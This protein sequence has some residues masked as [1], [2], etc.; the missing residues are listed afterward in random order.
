MLSNVLAGLLTGLPVMVAVGPIGL[1]L[2]EQ[3]L[4]RGVRTSAPAAI[5]VAAADLTFA[6]LSALVGTAV[7]HALEA[8][9]WWLRLGSAALMGAL[10]WKLARSAFAELRTTPANAMAMVAAS[11]LVGVGA[12]AGS[13][14]RIDIEEPMPTAPS[15]PFGSQRGARLAGSFYGLTIINPLTIV[16]FVGIV[17]AGGAGVGTFGWVVGMV[18]ASLTVHV[19]FVFAGHALGA[20]LGEAAAARVRIGAAALMAI[21]A[22]H[23]VLG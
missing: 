12:G 5:G 22:A 16:V 10:A 6:V 11:E 7:V 13:G 8:Y 23:F 17:A 9:S 14:G 21:L 4:E 2:I 20:A 3:G 18:L 19:G 15:V 1:L